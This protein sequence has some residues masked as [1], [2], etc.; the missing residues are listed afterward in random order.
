[1][2]MKKQLFRMAACLVAG[3]MLAAC[4]GSDDAIENTTPQQSP[5]GKV[6]L[7]GTLS[8][9]GDAATRSV[10]ADGTVTALTSGDKVYIYYKTTSNTWSEVEATISGTNINGD[11]EFSVEV[12]NPANTGEIKFI[13]P[14]D[15]AIKNQ[16][17]QGYTT[18]GIEEQLGTI[19]DINSKNLDVAVGNSYMMVTGDVARIQNND[20]IVLQNQLC[21][22][23]FNMKNA[24]GSANLSVSELTIS[25]ET[26]SY[27]VTP[28][29][30]TN[31]LYVAMLPV[32]N[33]EFTFTAT[34]SDPGIT[35][36]K[37]NN[38]TLG[39]VT[40]DNVGDVFDADGNIYSGETISTPTYTKT[41]N[42]V[43]LSA[44]DMY[45]TIVKLRNPITPVGIIAYVGSSGDV[46]TGE[47]YK[48]LAL[49]MDNSKRY[50]TSTGNWPSDDSDYAIWCA[51]NAVFCTTECSNDIAVVREWKDGIATTSYLINPL[52]FDE[53]HHHWAAMGARNYLYDTSNSNA[54][55][56]AGCSSWFLPSL[57]QWQLIIQGLISKKDG[58]PYSVPIDSSNQNDKIDSR[59]FNSILTNAGAAGL[60]LGD[61]WSCSAWNSNAIWS[62]NFF[63]GYAD[64][65]YKTDPHFV[66]AV[67]AF[68]GTSSGGG[69]GT[70]PGGGGGG[71]TPGGGGGTTPGGGSNSGTGAGL[72]A[73]GEEGRFD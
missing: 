54:A 29:S 38:V 3:A 16:N 31:E 22:C 10:A 30:A 12:E 66:R 17:T 37:L 21:I 50:N 68:G 48:G 23:K 70:T 19:D 51:Y 32:S 71:T 11:A 61:Y 6:M 42:G 45:N 41:Y 35:Y 7:S 72:S 14:A 5:T 25:D 59:Y 8:M 26:N 4:S 57:G 67:L 58:V 18:T 24:E 44:G 63:G 69:G 73:M 52:I 13:Y 43:T 28:T 2:L 56:P 46:E 65:I 9:N 15:R 62:V 34:G 64:F 55:L 40:S 1:M 60:S 36:T 27:T 47:S 20:K 49:A 33:K 53:N 39:T